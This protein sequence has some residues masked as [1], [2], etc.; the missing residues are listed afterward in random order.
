MA[1]RKISDLTALTAP[2]AGDLLPIVDISEAAAADKNKKITYSNFLNNIP[3][4]TITSTMILD[5]TILN[6]DINASAAIADTKLATIATAG[7]V[8]NSATTAN[9]ANTASAIVARDASGNFTA[10]TI[11]AALTGAASSNVLKAGDTMTGVLAVIA[12]TAAL[13]GIAVSG[14]TNTGIYSPG[15][16]QIGISTGGTSRIIFDAS[17][18]VNID[19]GSLYVDATNNYVGI[20]TTTPSGQGGQR[21]TVRDGSIAMQ[22]GVISGSNG[23]LRIIGRPDASN[24]NWAGIRA[25]S[26]A[27]CNNGILAFFT[28]PSNTSAESSTERMRLDSG[29]LLLGTSSSTTTGNAASAQ[30]IQVQG[31]SSFANISVI[32]NIASASGAYLTLAKS[33]STTPGGFTVVTSG[34]ELGGISFEGAD[35]SGYRNG[36]YISALVDGTPGASDMPGRLVL[37][38]TADG[39]SVPTERMRITNDGVICHDQ[40]TPATYAAATTLTVADLKTGIITYTGAAATLTLPTGTLTEGGFS[41]IY[42]NMTFEWSVINTGSGLCTIGAGTAHTITGGATIAAG[43]SGRFTSRRTAANTFISYRLS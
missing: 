7:K 23:E 41:G 12:G 30:N 3:T 5:G 20:S 10:G 22:N 32:S 42:T 21:L 35:G 13:P 25:I 16:D 38:T 26:D 34:D 18:N 29:R 2:V 8:S 24:Y 36:A 31:S 27:N 6:A 9:S 1:N 19:S 39:A 40:P 11:T 43:A 4:G 37:S 15:A 28:S 14:D 17:G 33:R